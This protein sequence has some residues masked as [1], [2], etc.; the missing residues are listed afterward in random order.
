MEFATTLLF[1]GVAVVAGIGAGMLLQLRHGVHR[2]FMVTITALLIGALLIGRE[3]PL[4]IS[5]PSWVR[6]A[7]REVPFLASI[8]LAGGVG[9]FAW[10]N[11]WSATA[12]MVVIYGFAVQ[13]LFGFVP[14]F[15]W[16]TVA[17][18]PL[19][20]GLLVA[21]VRS[22]YRAAQAALVC[23]WLFVILA[24]ATLALMNAIDLFEWEIARAATGYFHDFTP[25]EIAIMV[26]TARQ[27][28]VA[29][30]ALYLL[31]T[32][33]TLVLISVDVI[34]RLIGAIRP[35]TPPR[36]SQITDEWMRYAGSR[37]R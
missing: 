9:Y 27:R 5:L 18:P 35:P 14:I 4:P 8:I 13:A 7:E 28:E 2:A 17:L 16:G 24:P 20:A 22:R 34:E 12:M 21:V 37:R 23:G 25:A 30:T 15:G 1:N 32:L 31:V 19:V 33:G 36:T 11:R 6:L 10:L 26:A 29:A 3:G